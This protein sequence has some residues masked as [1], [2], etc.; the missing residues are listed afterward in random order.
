MSVITAEIRSG[1]NA[2]ASDSATLMREALTGGLQ[3]SIALVSS[4][5]AESALLLALAADVDPAVPVLF[6]ETGQHFP[7]TLAY[8]DHL[9]AHL[10]L[11]DVRNLAPSARA[12]H[13]RDPEGML[14]AF[15]P[16]ACCAL[17][18]VEPLDEAI[19]PFSAWISGRKRTQAMTRAE[20]PMIEATADGRLKLNPL[21]DWTPREIDAEITRR[22]LPRHPLVA[23]G[24]RSIGCAP[25]TRPVA[26]GEDAR[27]GRWANMN[28]TE[29]GIHRTPTGIHRT[30]TPVS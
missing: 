5:G 18:K 7:Q 25:C 19:I 13:D 11:T 20:L 2:A 26:A 27:A 16:D 3:G 1:L 10:G 24:Y 9:V 30:P 17:R 12:L 22:G 6:L 21:A 14:W 29:C 23:E 28:K 15:D 4:F 8:R